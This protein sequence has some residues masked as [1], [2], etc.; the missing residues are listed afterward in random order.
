MPISNL[1][2][3]Q[4]TALRPIAEVAEEAGIPEEA[5]VPF[6]RY[7]A[8]VNMAFAQEVASRPRGRV[9]L[10]TATTP[11][12]AGEGKTTISVGL[13]QAL[14]QMGRR[15]MVCLREPSL[16]PMFG[17]KGGATG[18]GRS[19]VLPMEA[20]NLHFTGD[21]HAVGSAHNLL[22][23]MVDNHLFH[24]GD[25]P[26]DPRLV[27][28]RRVMDMNDRALRQCVIGLGGRSDGVPRE[29]G[30]D[31]TAASEVMAIMGLA[32]DL[33]DLK[34]RL[35]RIVV[36]RTFEGKD[37]TARD[38]GAYGAMTALL[39]EALMP[40]L[41]QTVEGVPAFV[42]GGPF[43]NVA[44]GASSVVATRTALGL[45][46]LVVTEAG[47][48]SDLGAEKFFNIVCRTGGVEPSVVVLVTTIRSLKW[49]GGATKDSLSVEDLEVLERGLANLEGHLDSLGPFGLPVI[50]ALNRFPTDTGAE[51]RLVFDW[52]RDRGVPGAVSTVF[53]D[54]GTGGV[55]L[56]KKVLEALGSGTSRLVPRYSLEAGLRE[57][58]DT[59]ARTVYGADGV[60]F[61]EGA[62]RDLSD[63]E[64]RGY[65]RLPICMAKTQFSLSDRPE[66]RGRP[67]GFRVRVRKLGV[68]AGA[69][70][71]VV[72]C[73]PMMLMPGLPKQP[74]ALHVDVD[75]DGRIVGMF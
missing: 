75:D 19:Q 11:T 59:I 72:L 69:G 24:R 27:N 67:R 61:E 65:G 32:L 46:D 74:A 56:A 25:P 9:V 8:K 13:V 54:G 52:L 38:L 44:H 60:D 35:G 10:V 20:I 55:D 39:R 51:E 47:F 70:F 7:I 40:N 43:A 58:I 45:A 68:S 12:P 2:V 28:W 33:K 6:G 37:V 14:A 26:L 48:G 5:L 16:G 1:A 34:D 17:V 50:V 30:F 36:G 63:L 41:V 57:K 71:V 15:V 29:T 23:A 66:L 4:A 3:A 42:H 53:E 73:G 62:L 22:A 18:G 64:E 21:I 49:Q 31:I